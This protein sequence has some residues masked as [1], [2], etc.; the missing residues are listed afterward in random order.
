MEQAGVGARM[1][2]E[3]PVHTG[4]VIAA[5][6]GLIRIDFAGLTGKTVMVD[7]Q[8]EVT[9]DLHDGRDADGGPTLFNA[10]GV[11]IHHATTARPHVTCDINGQAQRID[12]DYVAGCDGFH[13]VSRQ[14][15]PAAGRR[16]FERV[17][18]FGWLGVLSRTPPVHDELIHAASGHGFALCSMRSAAL[19]RYCVQCP[20]TD[21]LEDWPDDRFRAELR[22]RLP[23]EVAGALITG[24]SIEK[25]MAPLRSFAT[26]PMRW[27][28]L[29]LAGDAAHTAPPPG[30]RG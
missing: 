30:P 17:Y 22:R 25:S 26:E 8:T 29:F 20:L 4:T 16:D 18:P 3:G 13:R 24:P 15:I 10:E 5:P 28:R 9:R 19:S 21:R 14:T 27:G 7:G 11:V 23:P 6:G 12:C 2:A 1:R